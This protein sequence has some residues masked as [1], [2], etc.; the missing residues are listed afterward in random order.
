MGIRLD[1][2]LAE[3]FEVLG[4]PHWESNDD[5]REL[6]MRVSAVLPMRRP[7]A[8]DT[9]RFRRLLIDATSGVTSRIFRLLE[10]V[11]IAAIRNGQER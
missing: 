3:R 7:S 5:L 1:Q 10:T 6:L 2:A 4:L 8:M 11:A 9:P